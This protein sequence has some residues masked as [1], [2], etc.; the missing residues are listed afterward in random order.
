MKELI[1]KILRE[2]VQ[3]RFVKSSQNIERAII[4]HMESLISETTRII[5]PPEDNYGNY[6][7]EWC[8]GGNAIIETRYYM[9]S[10]DE[11]EVEEFNSGTLFIDEEE[12]TFLSRMLQVRKQYILNVI[13]EW[14]DEKYTTKFGQ[15]VGHPEFEID[16]TIETDTPRKCYQ[17]ID[18][19]K[20]SRDEMIDYLD[21]QTLY[22]RNELENI[23]DN[24]L[25]SKYRS[26]YNSR[27]NSL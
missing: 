10:E 1:K 22:K 26:V 12:V 9:F 16:D 24:E 4:K 14:Y 13:T 23:S 8:K 6:G 5:P 19:D 2:E 27:L 15:E 25:K 21:N 3:K 17:M 11:D 18:T 7:E 20:L